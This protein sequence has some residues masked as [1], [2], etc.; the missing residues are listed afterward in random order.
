MKYELTPEEAVVIDALRAAVKKAQDEER[1]QALVAVSNIMVWLTHKP[2]MTRAY[3]A[4]NIMEAFTRAAAGLSPDTVI[5]KS[6]DFYS[7]VLK[8]KR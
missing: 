8:Q 6:I 3:L 5:R 4:R 7:G 1:N 2:Q